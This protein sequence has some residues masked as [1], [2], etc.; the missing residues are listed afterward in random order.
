MIT[1]QQKQQAAIRMSRIKCLINSPH[2]MKFYT[3]DKGKHGID[4]NGLKIY[5]AKSAPKFRYKSH[6]DWAYFTPSGLA[7]AINNNEVDKYYELML[8]HPQSDPNIWQNTDFEMELKSYYAA[9][10]GRASMI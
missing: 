5:L 2:N 3:P 7:D 1:K 8:K 9:R 6:I 4:A 10:V